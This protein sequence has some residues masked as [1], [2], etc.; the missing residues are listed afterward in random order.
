M[1]IQPDVS[2]D[3]LAAHAESIVELIEK[4]KVGPL[5]QVREFDKYVNLINRQEITFVESFLN[6]EPPRTFEEYGQLIE[7]YHQ[8][9]RNILLEFDQTAH[10]GL[11][12]VHKRDLMLHMSQAA[13]SC[14]EMLLNKMIGDYQTKSKV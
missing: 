9:S 12:E 8:L 14:K 11:F 4:H 3:I 5:M 6:A 7:K 13:N 10:I 2:K 1:Y